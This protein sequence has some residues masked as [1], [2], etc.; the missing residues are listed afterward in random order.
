MYEQEKQ[1]FR[2]DVSDHFASY[3]S[4]PLYDESQDK[5]TAL[6]AGFDSSF[7]GLVC[8][9]ATTPKA[10]QGKLATQSGVELGRKSWCPSL[11]T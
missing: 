1:M 11:W 5:W 2:S 9:G 8:T 3:Y 10:L 6:Q 4:S 7:T